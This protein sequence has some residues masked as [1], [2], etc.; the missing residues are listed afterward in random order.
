MKATT[1]AAAA[2][3]TTPATA[4][5]IT[6]SSC[7]AV[8]YSHLGDRELLA[9]VSVFFCCVLQIVRWTEQSLLCE[10]NV[11]HVSRWVVARYI[12]IFPSN[13]LDTAVRLGPSVAGVCDLMF[14]GSPSHP[15]RV[16]VVCVRMLQCPSAP[17]CPTSQN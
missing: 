10:G 3:P 7:L 1:T 2:T 16:A 4:T 15:R 12:V 9:P 8:F 6:P 14:T 5:T 11:T 17:F 13:V